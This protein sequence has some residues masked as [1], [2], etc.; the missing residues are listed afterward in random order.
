MEE[1]KAKGSRSINS[2][3]YKPT[4]ASHHSNLGMLLQE[5][6]LSLEA[7]G[8]GD[9]VRI[10]DEYEFAAAESERSVEGRGASPVRHAH[11]R[12]P[13]IVCCLRDRSRCVGRAV[14][15]DDVFEVREGLPEYA[16]HR[17]GQRTFPVV[18]GR[19]DTGRGEG[20]IVSLIGGAHHLPVTKNVKPT[21][22][23]T[24]PNWSSS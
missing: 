11:N 8:K 15:D 5:S 18:N 2:R 16:P 17:A 24:P 22:R 13:C 21:A 9:I 3:I 19:D 12:Y 14:I 7:F 10:L 23:L 4:L 1:R 6:D 20:G